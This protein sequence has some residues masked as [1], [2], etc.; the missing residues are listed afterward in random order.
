VSGKCA[1]FRG[2]IIID[3][4]HA[5]R[6]LTHLDAA[7][8]R[9]GRE[10][11]FKMRRNRLLSDRILIGIN[12]SEFPAENLLFLALELGL[13][14]AA[15]AVLFPRVAQANAVFFGFEPL[16]T[17]C[18]CKVYLEFWD[19]VKAQVQR[20]GSRVPQLLHLGVKWD[21]ADPARHQVARYECHPMLNEHAILQRVAAC[22]GSDGTPALCHIAQ[23][24]IRTAAWRNRG[25][26]MLYLEVS[27]EGNPRASYD[28]NLY[29]S[30]MTVADAGTQLQAAARYFGI[31]GDAIGA[32][33]ARLGARPFGHMSSGVDRHGNP[34]MSVYAE[35]VAL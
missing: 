1:L 20:T 12:T 17:S 27:E 23:D 26:S 31:P 2:N 6:L 16:D 33:L 15:H 22:H 24:L 32:Q 35:T 21:T 19:E 30:G 29:K 28:I 13:P 14:A 18:I 5:Q 4:T 9:F 25:A 11:A 3:A 7:R 34:F 8:I 10:D